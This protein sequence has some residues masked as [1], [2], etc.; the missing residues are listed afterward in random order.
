M[1]ATKIFDPIADVCQRLEF[2]RRRYLDDLEA[3][4][5]EALSSSPG[6]KARAGC[7][8]TYELAGMYMMFTG[9]LQSRSG[10]IIGPS[11]WVK[12]PSEFRDKSAVTQLFDDAIIGFSDALRNY[13]GDA[14]CDE[15]PSPFGPFTPLGMGNLAVWHTMYHSGQLNY[16]QTLHGDDEFHWKP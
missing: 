2:A 16:I 15:Y 1:N 6:G 5:E 8:V 11:E 12:A 3:M 14:I 10:E 7:D 4:S 13:S 9:L